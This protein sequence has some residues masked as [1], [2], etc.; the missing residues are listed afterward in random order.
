MKMSKVQRDMNRVA[1]LQGLR[2]EAADYQ[3]DEELARS[4]KED[5]LEKIVQCERRWGKEHTPVGSVF[6]AAPILPELFQFEFAT[7][8]ADGR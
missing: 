2:K 4:L 1:H 7:T 6:I 3:R 8:E 5:A